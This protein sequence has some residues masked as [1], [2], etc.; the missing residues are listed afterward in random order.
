MMMV[1]LIF[2]TAMLFSRFISRVLPKGAWFF[3]LA[4]VL[5]AVVSIISGFGYGMLL[6]FLRPGGHH[7]STGDYLLSGFIHGIQA[8]L[9]SPVAIWVYRKKPLPPVNTKLFDRYSP[10]PPVNTKPLDRY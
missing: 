4:T 9:F 2:G 6:A 7:I 5:T 8:A 3:V 10:V 1:F